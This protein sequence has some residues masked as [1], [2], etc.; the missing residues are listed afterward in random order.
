MSCR[1]RSAS[2]ASFADAICAFGVFDGVHEGHRFIIRTA[3]DQAR[4]AGVR[5]VIITF[6]KDPTELFSDAHDKLM[7]NEERLDALASLGADEVAVIA[8]DHVEASLPAEAFLGDTFGA[9]APRAVVVGEGFRFGQ[10][11]T[12]A[13]EDLARWGSRHGMAAW[14]LALLE[15]DGAPVTSTRIRACLR[16]GQVEEAARLLGRPYGLAG[17]VVSGRQAGREMGICTANLSV[18]ADRMVPADGVYAA[19]ARIG[20]GIHRAAVSIGVPVTFDGV[21]ES[22]IEAHI[23]DF[24]RDIYGEELGLSFVEHLRPMIRF[25]STED[26]VAQIERDIERAS[27]I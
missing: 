23:L 7:G 18:A 21:T 6:D 27:S 15:L 9:G 4:E 11:A 2:E 12:G 26:L 5:S 1:V 8:F 25:D 17:T 24:D 3:I 22:T 16:Q 13:I 14:E 10:G 19:F 20:D